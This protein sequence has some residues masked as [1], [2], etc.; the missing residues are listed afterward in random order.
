MTADLE[1]RLRDL[2]DQRDR[3]RRWAVRLEQE[4]ARLEQRVRFLEG[5][6]EVVDEEWAE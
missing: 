5:F 3:A 6:V 1:A 2:V 4:C